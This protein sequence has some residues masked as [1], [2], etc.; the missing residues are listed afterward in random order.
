MTQKG[1][2]DSYR[3]FPIG[4]RNNKAFRVF[5]VINEEISMTSVSDYSGSGNSGN[6]NITN[7]LTNQLQIMCLQH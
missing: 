5:S 7:M 3:D 1:V 2:R 4:G 6:A